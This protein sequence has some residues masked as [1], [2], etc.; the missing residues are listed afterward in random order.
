MPSEPS[1]VNPLPPVVWALFFLV[2]GI[3]VIFQAGESGFVGGREA[4]GWRVEALQRFGFSGTAF[5]WMLANGRWPMEHVQRF[6]TYLFVHNHLTATVFSGVMLLALGK[7]VGEAMGQLAV[8]ILFFGG[9]LFGSIVFGLVTNQQWL[10]GAFPGAYAL[11]GGYTYLMWIRL[12][13]KGEDQRR[14]FTF[15]GFLMGIQLFFSVFMESG[16]DWI[17]DIA[18][19][20]C[21]FALS[22]VVIPG[23]FQRLI[24]RIRQRD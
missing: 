20:A 23:G 13:Q 17:A 15:I 11:I 4:I 14:A 12:G 5:D 3:E 21:G 18:G 6:F 24:E 9:A 10:W 2:A 8:V 7:L 1:P 22:T 16:L 19:F